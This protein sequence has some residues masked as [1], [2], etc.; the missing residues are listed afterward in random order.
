VDDFPLPCLIARGS[1]REPMSGKWFVKG[2]M[3]LRSHE[4]QKSERQTLGDP[5]NHEKPPFQLMGI[6]SWIISWIICGYS[7]S[8]HGLV[9]SISI[10]EMT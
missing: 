5:K 9:M 10:G 6:I 2:M 7:W 1:A 4:T 3:S 8:S